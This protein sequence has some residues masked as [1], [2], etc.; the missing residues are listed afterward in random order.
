MAICL[1]RNADLHK[2]QLMP[3]PFTPALASVK[4]RIGFTFLVPG[5]PGKR[6][7]KHVIYERRTRSGRYLVADRAMRDANSV[8]EC[9]DLYSA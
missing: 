4:S 5:S 3:L 8:S 1:E 6:A 7:V 2:A 9:V